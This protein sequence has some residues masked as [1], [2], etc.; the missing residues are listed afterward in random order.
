MAFKR[1]REEMVEDGRGLAHVPL[2]G[3]SKPGEG[4]RK[5]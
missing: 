1:R 2:Q 5:R 3:S 4:R